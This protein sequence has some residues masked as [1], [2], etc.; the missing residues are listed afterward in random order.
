MSPR[1][2]RLLLVAALLCGLALT[3]CLVRVQAAFDTAKARQW[4][5]V[6]TVTQLDQARQEYA[7][8][9]ADL[10]AQ[11]AAHAVELTQLHR[12]L[13]KAQEALAHERDG[14]RQVGF[15]RLLTLCGGT[16]GS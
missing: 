4:Q 15:D 1:A 7:A 3:I 14:T 2:F 10:D 8:L 5:A 11:Q 9:H 13:T 12:D 16:P 6:A